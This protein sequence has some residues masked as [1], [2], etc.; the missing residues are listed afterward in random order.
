MNLISANPEENFTYAVLLGTIFGILT[1][2]WMLKIDYRQYPT[3]LHGRIIHVSLGFIA[4][5]LGAVAVPSL[6]QQNYTAITFLALAA[7]QFR[8][9]RNMERE[10]LSK[11]DQMELI[12]R[13]SVY[14][15]GIAMV[16]EGRNY[17]VIFV[18]FLTSMATVLLNS[19]VGIIVGFVS[20][21]ISHRLMSGKSVNHVA[22][23]EAAPVIMEGP[24]LYVGD[25]Y[26]MNVGLADSQQWIE[27]YGVGFILT[28]KNRD[29]R[30]TIAN[31]GQRQAILHDVSTVMIPF[32]DTGNPSLVPIAKLDLVDGRLAV[33]LMVKDT[34]VH[35]AKLVLE[36]VPLL[37]I[38][39]RMPTE[40][41]KE[42]G[43][44]S[45]KDE[46]RW[47]Q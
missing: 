20:L 31:V 25:I 14:I 46:K 15:E 18:A 2:V 26:M 22:H 1:R 29:C 9:V 27:K 36:R 3:Y 12:P 39:V 7:Q 17:L 40:A 42:M 19:W 8:D 37:E 32:T 13:G 5:A 47:K 45:G 43:A 4:A 41:I 30:V 23:I 28:P 16:F 34:D 35:K 6:F 33:F 38:A 21:F 44:N 10:T 24:D 11:V